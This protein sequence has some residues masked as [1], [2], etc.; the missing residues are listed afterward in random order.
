MIVL[1]LCLVQARAVLPLR[2]SP[3]ECT[4]KIVWL[5]APIVE[6]SCLLQSAASRSG[7]PVMRAIRVF[8][9]YSVVLSYGAGTSR[10]SKRALKY[11]EAFQ[12]KKHGFTLKANQVK[13]VTTRASGLS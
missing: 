2:C 5:E 7:S 11:P 13:I 12:T 6:V 1:I 9:V 10:A 4:S 8:N 3:I